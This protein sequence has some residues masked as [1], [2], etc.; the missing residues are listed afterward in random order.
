[1]NQPFVRAHKEGVVLAVHVQP[2]ASRTEAG[3][4]HGRALKIRVAA[5]PADGAAND[6]L[7]QFLARAC[8]IPRT[9]VEIE[10]GAKGRQKRIFLKGVSVTHVLDR[11]L[12]KGPMT[13]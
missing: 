6:A 5:P 11:L 12:W 1:M 7:A 9:A 13:A 2:R 8:S 3:G 4:L 10:S